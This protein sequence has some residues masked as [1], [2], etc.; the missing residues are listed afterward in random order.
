M[1]CYFVGMM[2]GR[3]F[4][5]FPYFVQI[6]QL[7]WPPSAVLVCDCSNKLQCYLVMDLIKLFWYLIHVE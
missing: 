5:K 3:C 7:I 2:Y 6:M 1:N 4:T